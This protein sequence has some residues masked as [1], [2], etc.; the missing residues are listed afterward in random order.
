ML[1]DDGG[2]HSMDYEYLKYG[3]HISQYDSTTDI[4]DTL[5][6]CSTHRS[7]THIPYLNSEQALVLGHADVC[8]MVLQSLSGFQ[9]DLFMLNSEGIKPDLMESRAWVRSTT[10][11]R[12]CLPGTTVAS[13]QQLLEW[14]LGLADD[15]YFCRTVAGAAMHASAQPKNDQRSRRL[16]HIT[17]GHVLLSAD[18]CVVTDPC[19]CIAVLSDAIIP[20]Y[21]AVH[22][23]CEEFSA[24]TARLEKRVAGAGSLSSQDLD[25]GTLLTMYIAMLPWKRLFSCMRGMISST[26][27]IYFHCRAEWERDEMDNATASEKKGGIAM[28]N[29]CS[30]VTP[31]GP[32]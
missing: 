9:N 16:G 32:I 26:K 25:T 27:T 18:G 15:A 11:S 3:S 12:G 29:F 28:I 5:E 22:Q 23:E 19:I 4:R 20:L 2:T 24:C 1:D 30:H 8:R 31:G 14:F 6:L 21:T 7:C 13:T 10:A 17:S